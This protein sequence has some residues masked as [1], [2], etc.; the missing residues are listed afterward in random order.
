MKQLKDS[1][2]LSFLSFDES[3]IDIEMKFSY[4]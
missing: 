3:D 4:T 2:S 1:K